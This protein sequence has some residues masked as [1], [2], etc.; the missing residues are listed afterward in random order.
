[1]NRTNY[2]QMDAQQLRKAYRAWRKTMND[3]SRVRGEVV[4]FANATRHV[5]EIERIAAQQGINLHER[6]GA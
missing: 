3:A 5:E 4:V 1:M 6:T 2:N